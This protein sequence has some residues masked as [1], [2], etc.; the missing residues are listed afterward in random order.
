MVRPNETIPVHLQGLFAREV[1]F[2]QNRSKSQSARG[3]TSQNLTLTHGID[4]PPALKL[5]NNEMETAP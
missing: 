3:G 4:K 2:E 5:L 1:Q